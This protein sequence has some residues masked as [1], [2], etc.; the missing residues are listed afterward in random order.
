MQQ[1]NARLSRE[2]AERRRAEEET[3]ESNRQL[4]APALGQLRA[5]QEQVIQRERMHALGRMAN[6][7]AHDFN[8]TLAPILGFSEL[9]VMK[10]A[11]ADDRAKLHSYLE[12]ILNG[13]KD[14]AKVVSRLREF[15]RLSR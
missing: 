13:A 15:Y 12:M 8:N 2:I 1:A 6:G 7:I 14:A 3:L 5:S 10:P 9:L 4:A 11:L